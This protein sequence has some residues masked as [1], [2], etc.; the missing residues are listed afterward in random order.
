MSA[1]EFRRKHY[2]EGLSEL[3]EINEFA[4]AYAAE[5]NKELKLKI[6]AALICT[7][8]DVRSYIRVELNGIIKRKN[9]LFK[10]ALK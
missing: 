10:Q 3:W 1:I 6:K 4:E 5:Q 2:P 8:E 7:N 9:I